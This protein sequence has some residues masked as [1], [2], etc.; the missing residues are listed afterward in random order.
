ME[1]G[2]EDWQNVSVVLG[3]LP[4]KAII[5]KNVTKNADLVN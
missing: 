2:V 1:G 4:I 3:T 5:K